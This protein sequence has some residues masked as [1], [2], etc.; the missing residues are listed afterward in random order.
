MPPF[1]WS[2][3][4]LFCFPGEVRRE[5]LVENILCRVIFPVCLG[6]NE[7]R[8]HEIY[9]TNGT[10]NIESIQHGSLVCS[11]LYSMWKFLVWLKVH[12]VLPLEVQLKTIDSWSATM[13]GK[14]KDMPHCFRRTNIVTILIM[15][16]FIC[17]TI[18][19]DNDGCTVW[20]LAYLILPRRLAQYSTFTWH[21]R[22]ME[23]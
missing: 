12:L 7:L 3:H 18:W 8:Y 2:P 5:I 6:K 14:L 20:T 11:L 15:A 4:H 22:S 10:Y 13:E 17:R 9:R 23:R 21:P 1:L 19:R 16:N